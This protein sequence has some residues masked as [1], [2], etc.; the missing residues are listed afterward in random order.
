MLKSDGNDHTNCEK[1]IVLRSAILT[2]AAWWFVT[3]NV[4][5]VA[6]IVEST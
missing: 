3:Y 4:E 2:T 5:F 6:A 1:Q